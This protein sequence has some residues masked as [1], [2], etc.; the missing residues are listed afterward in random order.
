VL[1]DD[2]A[3]NLTRVWPGLQRDS[4]AAASHMR[5]GWQVTCYN[6]QLRK[7]NRQ[8]DKHDVPER[9]VQRVIDAAIRTNR[10]ANDQPSA[11]RE[12]ALHQAIE[13]PKFNL[14]PSPSSSNPLERRTRT[15]G[16]LR[17]RRSLSGRT[18]EP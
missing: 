9:Y 14:T 16:H 10:N 13:N 12:N 15:Y 11:R 17:I 18:Q 3:R 2:G 7:R 4:A 5:D 6:R 8:T 1:E